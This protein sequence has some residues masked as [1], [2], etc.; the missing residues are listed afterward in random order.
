MSTTDKTCCIISN[1]SLGVTLAQTLLKYEFK[2]ICIFTQDNTLLSW[3]KSNSIPTKNLSCINGKITLLCF[4]FLFSFFNPVILSDMALRSAL[5]ANINYHNSL[6]PEYR[7]YNATSWAILD[8]KRN[9]G[10]TWHLMDK[11]ID[12]GEILLQGSVPIHKNDTASSL[13]LRCYEAAINSLPLLIKKLL[14]SNDLKKIKHFSK[15]KKSLFRKYD[16]PKNFGVINWNWTAEEILLIYNALTFSGYENTM[17][18]PKCWIKEKLFILGELYI[19]DH[20]SSLLPGTL[21]QFKEEELVIK[22]RTYPISISKLYTL[23]G[24]VLNF[25]RLKNDL[26]LLNGQSISNKANL[27]TSFSGSIEKINNQDESYWITVL[28]ELTF[29]NPPFFEKHLLKSKKKS[30]SVAQLIMENLDYRTNHPET[31]LIA[32]ILVHLYKTNN[33]RNLTILQA[34]SIEKIRCKSV[35][36]F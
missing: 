29:F 10:F 23:D 14:N 34:I 15:Q 30:I 8:G 21:V 5:V 17:T 13:N 12:Q 9:H 33:Y 6:L 3:A 2:I 16:I 4:S 35:E 7:G 19:A 22:T 32:P 11:G 26:N 24:E 36:S 31:V 1:N 27:H 18:T 25:N 20:R 28:S